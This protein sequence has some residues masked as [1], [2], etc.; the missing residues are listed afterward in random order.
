MEI[1]KYPVEPKPSDEGEEYDVEEKIEYFLRPDK[2]I[3]D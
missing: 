2:I 3:L 1:S